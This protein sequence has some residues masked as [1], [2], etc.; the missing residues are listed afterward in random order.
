MAPEPR[1]NGNDD[2]DRPVGGSLVPLYGAGDIVPGIQAF[3]R[4]DI[5]LYTVRGEPEL[6]GELMGQLG[7]EGIDEVVAFISHRTE[8]PVPPD[9]AD[10]PGEEAE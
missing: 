7:K 9:D 4:G 5:I 6:V 10:E 1:D 2:V 3:R 8:G